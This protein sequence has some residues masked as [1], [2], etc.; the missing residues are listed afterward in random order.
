MKKK[1]ILLD[2]RE[3]LEGFSSCIVSP[4]FINKFHVDKKPKK[5]KKLGLSPEN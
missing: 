1:L 4:R 5:K 3:N 2:P